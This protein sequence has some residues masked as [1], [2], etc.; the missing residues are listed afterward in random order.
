M[1]ADNSLLKIE[2]SDKIVLSVTFIG[3]MM[4]LYFLLF[5]SNFEILAKKSETKSETSIGK[6]T[7]R[8]SDTRKKAFGA[9]EWKTA[10]ANQDIGTGDSVFSGESS[11]AQVSF[12]K[13]GS[14]DLAPNTLINF[15]ESGGIE[16]PEVNE[17]NIR[18]SIKDKMK[19]SI[20]GMVGACV[21]KRS[22]Y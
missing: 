10:K 3:M 1:A 16:I 12:A 8:G 7:I 9:F 6:L 5:D 17:G 19:V 18:L 15:V 22:L 21:I 14:I 13:G 11:A 20:G 4:T 2:R